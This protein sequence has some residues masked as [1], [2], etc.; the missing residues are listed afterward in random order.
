MKPILI[1]GAKG[2]LGA[3]LRA[4]YA[5]RGL[6][7]GPEIAASSGAPKT[8]AFHEPEGARPAAV[9]SGEVSR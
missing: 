7:V 2:L 5:E 6:A 8:A 3:N 4:D 9:A 1:T